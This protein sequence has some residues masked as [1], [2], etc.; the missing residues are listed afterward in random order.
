MS[1]NCF[2]SDSESE[3]SH[4]EIEERIRNHIKKRKQSQAESD[5]TTNG[6]TTVKEYLDEYKKKRTAAYG[7]SLPV[8]SPPPEVGSKIPGSKIL[9][10]EDRRRAV[11]DDDIDDM[12]EDKKKKK[13]NLLKIKKETRFW[14]SFDQ[15]T[16]AEFITC[17]Y[18]ENNLLFEA[19][20]SNKYVAYLFNGTYSKRIG[21]N[22]AALQKGLWLKIQELLTD[23]WKEYLKMTNSLY[24]VYGTDFAHIETQFRD[25]DWEGVCMG[26][27]VNIYKD[28]ILLL[29]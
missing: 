23:K 3:N 28:A 22:H 15:E 16:V 1:N 14:E 9:V 12:T 24:S 19:S 2:D 13:A 26:K 5:S 27:E 17:K 20:G 4:N 8:A 29:Y 7:F 25:I 6:S 18:F 10:S 21:E 11:S